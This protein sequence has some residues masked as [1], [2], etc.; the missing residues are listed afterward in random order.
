MSCWAVQFKA[1]KFQRW[2]TPEIQVIIEW[3]KKPTV[4]RGV[5][6]CFP[7]LTQCCLGLSTLN[8][9]SSLNIINLHISDCVNARN[10]RKVPNQSSFQGP[11]YNP[12]VVTA[13]SLQHSA[14]LW[15]CDNVYTRTLY[16][17]FGAF[18]VILANFKVKLYPLGVCV[19]N[20]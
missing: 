13:V 2:N 6:L 11:H 8:Q 15:E 12:T 17:P 16:R 3:N 10:L 1:D 14:I 4:P 20:C 19:S 18:L 7:M 9:R 5:I